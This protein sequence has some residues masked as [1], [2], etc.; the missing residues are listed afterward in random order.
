MNEER[1]PK[2]LTPE[3]VSDIPQVQDKHGHFLLSTLKVLSG[4][5]GP[6]P[7]QFTAG[8]SGSVTGAGAEGSVN[9]AVEVFGKEVWST[10]RTVRAGPGQSR[11]QER[12]RGR[13]AMQV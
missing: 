1:R 12:V 2:P 5:V 8:L 10:K 11:K 6:E 3:D 4:Q 9:A 7:V 13:Y